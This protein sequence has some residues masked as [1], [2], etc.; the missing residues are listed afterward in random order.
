M[1]S[2]PMRFT[3]KVLLLAVAL[4]LWSATSSSAQTS[5]TQEGAFDTANYTCAATCTKTYTGVGAVSVGQMVICGVSNYNGRTI[6]A[7]TFGGQAMSLGSEI[8]SGFDRQA[9]VYRYVT[10]AESGTDVVVTISG[11][12]GN[13]PPMNCLV[14]AGLASDQ[15]S[16]DGASNVDGSLDSHSIGPV[17][18][19]TA[20]NLVVGWASV[21][22]NRTWTNDAGW[23]EVGTPVNFYSMVWDS[24]SSASARTWTF[25]TMDGAATADVSIVAFNGTVAVGNVNNPFQT[26]R[27][28]Q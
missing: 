23:D 8:A 17:T 21:R 20:E 15:S 24:Q 3:S 16:L 28:G 11:S 19:D 13:N 4:L 5:V 18:P 27:S 26:V 7:Y 14:A 6:S 1:T 9:I 22:G 12:D 2:S 25:S 10:G